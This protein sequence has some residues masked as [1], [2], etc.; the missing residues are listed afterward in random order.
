LKAYK[1]AVKTKTP[2]RRTTKENR[3]FI[4]KEVIVRFGPRL[5]SPKGARNGV[6]IRP[7]D[8]ANKVTKMTKEIIP[9]GKRRSI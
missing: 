1:L 8:N 2:I 5:I 7:K 4:G 6:A 9:N 3:S